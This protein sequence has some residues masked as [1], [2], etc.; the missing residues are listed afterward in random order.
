LAGDLKLASSSDAESSAQFV[1]DESEANGHV[2]SHKWCH[3]WASEHSL[4]QKVCDRGFFFVCGPVSAAAFEP[5]RQTSWLIEGKFR[6]T[7]ALGTAG[8]EK[9]DVHMAISEVVFV[10]GFRFCEEMQ[11]LFWRSNF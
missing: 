7:E 1:A 3:L 5:T 6:L 10:G 8:G 11:I 2:Q 4:P 9:G